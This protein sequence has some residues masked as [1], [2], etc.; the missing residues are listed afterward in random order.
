MLSTTSPFL[1]PTI[2]VASCSMFYCPDVWCRAAVWFYSS[3]CVSSQRWLRFGGGQS[4]LCVDSS[5]LYTHLPKFIKTR[6]SH[7]RKGAINDRPGSRFFGT[8]VKN[9]KHSDL[10]IGSKESKVSPSGRTAV[11]WWLLW[12][13]YLRIPLSL[14][15]SSSVLLAQGYLSR[16]GQHEG[17]GEGQGT[18][19]LQI[20][21]LAWCKLLW[22]GAEI[23]D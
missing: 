11:F 5:S 17:E 23:Q 15:W 4:D 3:C 16:M 12:V 8:P 19:L 9:L 1:P 14:L 18:A 6:E 22:C 2:S 13:L 20:P 10:V 7:L 21:A